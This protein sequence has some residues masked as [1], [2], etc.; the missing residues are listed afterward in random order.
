MAGFCE[1]LQFL[2]LL[3]LK[4]RLIQ[5]YWVWYRIRLDGNKGDCWAFLEV[6]ALLSAILIFKVAFHG[7]GKNFNQKRKFF[8]DWFVPAKQTK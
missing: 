2:Y 6:C 5:D 4:F 7:L 8:I 1:W 3:S